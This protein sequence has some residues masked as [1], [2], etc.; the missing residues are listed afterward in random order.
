MTTTNDTPT[1][2]HGDVRDIPL[3]RLKKSPNNARRTPH[4]TEAI[5]ALAA[6]IAAKGML[7]M[8]VVEPEL[9]VA[10]EQTGYFLV[11]IGEGRRQAQLL[12]AKRKEIKKTELI[13]CV[14]DTANDAH[15]I[16]LDENVTR[17]AMHPADE[18]E[19]FQRMAS[20]RGYGAGEIGARFGVSAAVVKQRL[21]LAS[22][23]PR[24]MQAYRD[25]AL[26]LDQLMAFA[27][28][29]D[30]LRQEAV[31]ETL[32]PWEQAGHIRR[33]LMEDRVRASDRRAVFV[34]VEAYEAAGGVVERDLFAED[35]GGYFVSVPLLEQLAIEKLEA[36]ATEVIAAGWKWAEVGLNREPVAGM[37]RLYPEVREFTDDEQRVH[38]ALAADLAELENEPWSE[39]SEA[40]S[41]ELSEQIDALIASRHAF[42]PESMTK[43]GAFL[44]IR[45]NGDAQIE[46]GFVRPDDA[47]NEEDEADDGS[48]EE[49]S[50]EPQK[51]PEP[52]PDAAPALSDKLVANLTAH[53]TAALRD[54]IA[55][56]PDVAVFALIHAF[57]LRTFSCFPGERT[58][59]E[60]RL[61]G[62]ELRGYAPG[63]ENSR[64]V[65]AIAERHE[66]WAARIAAAESAESFVDGLDAIE[67]LALL[68]HCAS[69]TLNDVQTAGRRNGPN[70]ADSL[71]AKVKLNM[72]TYWTPT[73]DSY[74]RHV[75]KAAIQQAVIEA[76]GP[77]T[78]RRIAGAKKSDMAEAA[79]QLVADTGWLPDIL[80]TEG[81][82]PSDAA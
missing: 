3:N 9:S 22:V 79:E 26:T 6:S 25:E 17:S 15:E 2:D 48:S 80:R 50:E 73:A 8:P 69:L 7:Q 51:Q 10:R 34:G 36:L 45:A 77:D 44:S 5:E 39:A 67:A 1:A 76:A 35:H 74:F 24:L 14:V 70:P 72:A 59:L 20:E 37:P 58:C 53:R 29:E 21:R 28:T 68:A 12:R 11:T 33:R 56:E 54:A 60:V 49:G 66:R 30:H 62:A 13:R 78:A 47:W 57:V 18:F 55:D 40:R 65:Q 81:A 52:E 38:D 75:N 64:A 23:S 42:T 4:A 32:Q 41:V 61:G 46:Y 63:I 19:A 71:A 16:S 27:V 82:E 31:F 43:S